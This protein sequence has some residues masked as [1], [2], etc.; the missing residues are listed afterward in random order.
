MEIIELFLWVQYCSDGA[1]SCFQN[2]TGISVMCYAESFTGPFYS[3][4][5]C[6]YLLHNLFERQILTCKKANNAFTSDIS[7]L[8]SPF[9]IKCNLCSVISVSPVP[10]HCEC[11]QGFS[12]QAL[13]YQALD[14]SEIKLY[15]R[16]CP[17]EVQLLI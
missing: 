7:L 16:R 1:Y 13:V 5:F 17:F 6:G 12:L 4:L 15:N 14:V 9:M 2:Q 11:M 10:I 8:F 3:G